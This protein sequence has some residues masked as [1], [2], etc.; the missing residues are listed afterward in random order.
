MQS[1]TFMIYLLLSR[2]NLFLVILLSLAI[3][4]SAQFRE[5]YNGSD[6]NDDINGISFI[7]PSTGFAAF[8]KFIG[9]TQDSGHS[10]IKR[11]V[12]YS[13]LDLGGYTNVNFTFG[14]YAYGVVAFSKDSL[15]IYG[16]F[17]AEPSILFSAN[18]GQSWK[19][20]YHTNFNGDFSNA[21]TDMKLFG[22]TGIAIDHYQILRTSN[23][24]Q[25]WNT[26]ALVTDLE[27]ISFP[28]SSICYVIGGKNL[29]KSLNG[30]ISWNAVT[31]PPYVN[32]WA[33]F[34]NVFFRTGT[35]GYISQADEAKIFRTTDGG[36][37]WTKMND[38]TKFPAGG[39]D[40][41]FTN[42]ST[43]FL[44]GGL[45]DVYKTTDS[46][47]IWE[48]CSKTSDYQY[49]YYGLNTLHFYNEQIGWT[50]GNGEYL[51]ITT[52][53]GGSTIP[54]V[55]FDVDTSEL[56][57]AQK[58]NLINYTKKNYQYKWFKNDTLISTEYNASYTHDIY[59]EVDTIMLIAYNTFGADTLIKY[60]HFN[61]PPPPPVPVIASFSPTEGVTGTVVT[62][63]GENF[64]GTTA[65][66]FGE[67][68]AISF[69]V[70]SG[71]TITAEVGNGSSGKISVTNAYG[72]ATK[73]GFLY[74]TRLKI[75]SFSPVYGPVG[76]VVTINGTNF[77]SVTSDNIVYFGAVRATIVSATDSTLKV[78]VPF[79]AGYEPI[80][81]T[82]NNL[83]A[84]SNLPF[85]L[86]FEGS[87]TIDS[88][89]FPEKKDFSTDDHTVTISA[90]DFDGDGKADIINGGGNRNRLTVL[91]NNSKN[92]NVSF[93]EK[94]FLTITDGYYGTG[95]F[96]LCDING[97]GKK[98]ILTTGII[99][100]NTS[101]S[102]KISF[103]PKEGIVTDSYEIPG[104][105]SIADFDGDGKPDIFGLQSADYDGGNKVIILQNT[106]AEDTIS[107]HGIPS[108]FME[109]YNSGDCAA[110]DFDGDGKPDIA[111]TNY[112]GIW[113]CGSVYIYRNTSNGGTIS[114]AAPESYP[115][116]SPGGDIAVGDLDGDGKLDLAVTSE[117]SNTDPTKVSVLRN[118]STTGL[119]S[120]APK[121]DFTTLNTVTALKIADLDGDN[122]ADLV[123]SNAYNAPVSVLKNTG[124][125]GIISFAPKVDFAI[126]D[127][128]F[129][130]AVCVNDFDADGKPD[131]A[132]ANYASAS[133]SIFQNKMG[134]TLP[135]QLTDFTGEI[136][137]NHALLQWHTATELN[138][139]YFTIEYAKDGVNFSGIGKT[140]AAGNSTA[141][142]TYSFTHSNPSEGFN[143]YRLKMVDNDGKFT[144]SSVIKLLL[145]E[146][147]PSK[148]T[149][150]PNPAGD[151]AFVKHPICRGTIKVINMYGITV[152]TVITGNESTTK[153]GL[154]DLAAGYYKIEWTDGIRMVRKG[155]IKIN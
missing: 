86:T 99:F 25:S 59:K 47:T 5:K 18:Q 138:T 114:F 10:F 153:V 55:Y 17:G 66:N 154:G 134:T 42:D 124:S 131:I 46:G 106:S 24:G 129:A 56:S 15:L 2:A 137:N 141:G 9:F 101:T 116:L 61:V 50:G 150:Y 147:N 45:Y 103:G 20:V 94:E 83:T 112:D 65:V 104:Y 102:G 110:G 152:K 23:R 127:Y 40:M 90:C 119:I 149:V 29:Y 69:T 135:L 118:T 43:G 53:A 31:L 155:L 57:A 27:K 12:T 151:Y 93:G 113:C 21:I 142:H 73:S 76:T 111:V 85:N 122:N 48:R 8:S 4:S 88:N 92:G 120:F 13:N 37:S 54:R 7:S 146:E 105:M 11:T 75:N 70:V 107:F 144:Y 6:K 52:N 109:W 79:G 121:I 41:Y 97:D 22:N 67:T 148:M 126:E 143:Y 133:V 58:V 108:L 84:Y 132:T 35:F 64:T 33:D 14:F 145:D 44:S 80:S 125:K 38:E 60:Q 34:N 3:N 130:Y 49:L 16:H 96:V 117:R 28:S 82:V 77:S 115:V 36:L 89:S 32:S 136:K 39:N 71:I 95:Q 123:L 51:M 98:D 74:K 78:T 62:I 68:P 100:R 26:S 91:P 128:P 140:D 63:T 87:G 19:L 81:V 30:G 72:T 1:K 139:K